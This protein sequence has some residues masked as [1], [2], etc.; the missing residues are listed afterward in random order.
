M[1][2]FKIFQEDQCNSRE[3]RSVSSLTASIGIPSYF[4]Q[5]LRW[6]HLDT[7]FRKRPLL[8][9][10]FSK[11]WHVIRWTDRKGRGVLIGSHFAMLQINYVRNGNDLFVFYLSPSYYQIASRKIPRRRKI[12][13]GLTVLKKVQC[14]DGV[15]LQY[16]A[17]EFI[18]RYTLS[19]DERFL[20]KYCLHLQ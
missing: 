9:F 8:V 2:H 10:L 19:N 15:S 20:I 17:N 12:V 18:E 6:S 5:V 14:E 13:A 7:A 3:M 16:A 1:E 4:F 11:L